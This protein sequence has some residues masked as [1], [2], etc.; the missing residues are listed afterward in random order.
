MVLDIIIFGR[1]ILPATFTYPC[2]PTC[3]LYDP[4]LLINWVSYVLKFRLLLE[5]YDY[6]LKY[7]NLKLER[8]ANLL[9]REETESLWIPFVVFANTEGNEATKGT[10]D[11]EMTVTREGS[12]LTSSTDT[13]EEI[14][15]FNGQENRIAFQQVYSKTFKCQYQLHLYPFDTQVTISPQ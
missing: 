10:E 11:T 8:S 9:T 12:F 5:W 6:R 7:H 13:V 3:S 15:I 2:R 14:N 1:P 4:C